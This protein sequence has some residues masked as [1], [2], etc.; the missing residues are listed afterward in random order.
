MAVHL[1]RPMLA[2]SWLGPH[3][4]FLPAA[5]SDLTSVCPQAADAGAA[6]AGLP[7][8]VSSQLHPVT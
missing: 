2:L 4:R 8:A 1:A 6:M 7:T 3:G 5:P